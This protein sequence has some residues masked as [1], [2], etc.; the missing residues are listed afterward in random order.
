[1]KQAILTGT[2]SLLG[3]GRGVIALCW[4]WCCFSETESW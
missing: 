2:I 3:G 1:M 4:C